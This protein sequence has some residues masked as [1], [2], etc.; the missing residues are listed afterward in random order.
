[1]AAADGT[2]LGYTNNRDP[3]HVLRM[4][5]EAMQLQKPG[6]TTKQPQNS[7]TSRPETDPQFNPQSPT[8]GLVVR[9]QAKVLSGYEE[10]DSHFEKVFQTALS[11]D[12]LWISA[13]ETNAM[14]DGTFPASLA[15]RIARF[16]LVDNTRGEPPMWNEDEVV[17]HRFAVDQ[18]H[19]VGHVELKSKD[20]S[21]SYSAD[22]LGQLTIVDRKV[23]GMKMVAKG[24]FAGEGTYTR[25]APKDPFPLAI[26]FTLADGTDMADAIPPQGSRGWLRGYI[27]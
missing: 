3:Q 23:T 2:F 10:P 6:N 18:G 21:R 5:K 8:A 17:S 13:N 25:N 20:G 14:I 12:N 27:Q 24:T 9:V 4:L 22:L 19:I 1:M 26:S 16:H 11:R 15:I 7:E